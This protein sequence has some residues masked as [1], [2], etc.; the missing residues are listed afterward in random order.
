[1]ST[2]TE[3]RSTSAAA[4]REHHRGSPWHQA[5]RFLGLFLSPFV[6]LLAAGLIH[7]WIGGVHLRG[8]HGD[9]D[10]GGHA[11]LWMIVTMAFIVG[12]TGLTAW[13]AWDFAEHR[14]TSLRAS[15]AGSVGLVGAFFAVNV[16]L[17]P[18]WRSAGSFIIATWAVA[19]VWSVAR[20]DV[21]RN[22]KRTD[23]KQ[24]EDFLEK[25]GLKGWRVRKVTPIA[26]EK[27]EPLATRVDFQH[28]EGDT[29]EQL[30]AARGSFESGTSSPAD[31]SRVNADDRADRSSIT[32]MH[33]DPLIKGFEMPSF[34]HRGGSIMNPICTGKYAD[35]SFEQAHLA[36]GPGFSPSGYMFMGMA[37]AGKTY[38]ENIM[39]SDG[40]ISR[41]D[42]VVLYLNRA[43]G[44]QD[45]RPIIPGVEAA[46][47][48]ADEGS[49]PY[50]QALAQVKRMIGYRSGRLALFGIDEWNAQQCWDSPPWR[51]D[52][53][54]GRRVQ[55]E[56]MPAL[57]VHVGE[58][59]AIL[60]DAPGEAIYI[61]SKGLSVGIIPGW[62]L[63]RAS[64]TRMPTDLRFNIGAVWCFGCGDSD[65]ATMALSDWVVKAGAHPENWKNRKPGYH[66]FEGPGIDD[67]KFVVP[68][69]TPRSG[70]NGADLRDE[71]LRRNLENAPFMAKL[72]RG[73][74][75]ATGAPG[76]VPWWDQ[77]AEST[78]ELRAT[79]LGQA[80]P[81]NMT[82]SDQPASQ[83]VADDDEDAEDVRKEMRQEM[84][85]T[86]EVEGLELYPEDLG[87]TFADGDKP[88][89]AK[90]PPAE[91][92]T[93]DDPKPAPR[94]RAAA[95]EA[96]G[97][98]AVELSDDPK[99]RDPADPTGCTV[100]VTA[101][102]FADRYPF[103]SRPW[104]VEAFNQA[105]AGELDLPG[106]RTLTPA[107][108]LGAADGKYRLQRPSAGHAR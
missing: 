102:L 1:M 34:A 16:A 67:D 98:A 105:A 60:S 13:L 24:G 69:R 82:A 45:A 107:P 95:V 47:I 14:K 2:R 26:D 84:K 89:P 56:R 93:W 23:E 18:G 96:F 49:G 21:T 108:D 54:T 42:A 25:H 88:L 68:A 76:E 51:T 5:A 32:L 46:V 17:G 92:L 15:L 33:R 65:S 78:D 72:D 57:V 36:G 27:G 39:L 74:A 10:L 55:M 87:A 58:A 11:L 83:Q 28:A 44:L 61:M 29:V 79:L 80:Q 106:S 81:A 6:G 43:K 86:T 70:P 12:A 31:M 91:E 97:K 99:L 9:L 104:F 50:R 71:L 30:Y 85:E 62:S 59:D 41:R 52:P 3:G 90:L 77:V 20:L 8:E 40:V 63:Q 19:V 53:D 37:R 7:L 48:A 66:Y 73:T 103:R 64:A 35:G 101:A 4:E 38:A 22:D 100:I 94:D 75:D